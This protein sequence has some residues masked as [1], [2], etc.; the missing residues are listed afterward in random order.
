MASVT[1]ASAANP[2]AIRNNVSARPRRRS[3]RPSSIVP[4]GAQ[5]P[6]GEPAQTVAVVRA[7]GVDVVEVTEPEADR[8]EEDPAS[9][10]VV[11]RGLT[12]ETAIAQSVPKV[13]APGVWSTGERGAGRVIAVIDTGVASTFGGTLVGQA[14][15]AANATGTVGYCGPDGNVLEAFDSTCFTL[16]VCSGGDVLDEAAGRPCPVPDGPADC[17]HG[18]AVAAV[19]AR[20]D[21]PEGVAPDAGVYAVRVFDPT[22]SSA[23]LVDVLLALDHIR[24]LAD[25]GMDVAAVN[26]SLATSATFAGICDSTPGILAQATA[27]KALFD[28]LRARGIATAVASG[29]DFLTGRVGFP[30]CV[31]SAVSVG[32]SDLDDDLADFGNRGP[33]LDLVAPGARE[34]NGA[35]TGLVIPGSPVTSWAGTSFA[36]PRVA[37]AF[38]LLGR[39]FPKASVDQLTGFL[40]EIGVPVA[41][42]PGGPGYRRLRVGAPA[43]ILFGQALFPTDAPVP[44]AARSAVG[45]FDGDG[46]ADVLGHVPG[47]GTDHVSYGT[48]GWTVSNRNHSVSGSYVPLTGNF[49]GGVDSPDDILWYAPG[50]AADYLWRGTNSRSFLSSGVSISG[51]YFPIVGDFDGDGWDDVFWYAPGPR[52]DYVWYGGASGFTSRSRPVNGYYRVGAGDVNGD[53]RDDVVFHGPNSA[54]DYLWRGTATK[55]SFSSAPLSMG[56]DYTIRVGDVDGNGADDLLLYQAGGRADAIWRGGSGVTGAGPTGGFSPRPV[57]VNGSYAP[58]VGDVDGDGFDDILWYAAGG[59]PDFLWMGSVTGAPVSRPIVAGGIYVPLLA[60]LD[61]D[62]GDD[63]VWSHGSGASSPLWWSHLL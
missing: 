27:F 28:Q 44:G 46:R 47:S 54:T 30:A 19:A 23:D 20:H 22:G 15:F 16:G 31:S 12:V 33:G 55:G 29:N 36:A 58:V 57:T 39:M 11:E 25:A 1:A 2:P 13:G 38:A 6:E 18:S 45:D 24:A 14:C 41:D 7:D 8:L 59:A 49:L 63:V 51:A 62:G 61:A 3:A 35:V 17:A 40:R 48:P 5:D 32:A 26:L 4:A 34:G 56:G 9:L 53:G 42:G 50:S 37:G 43:Q 21:A 10:A 52:G 60:D